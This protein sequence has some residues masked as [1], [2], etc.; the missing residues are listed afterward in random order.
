MWSTACSRTP[1][2][3]VS[4]S[5]PSRRASGE[6]SALNANGLFVCWSV[7]VLASSGID[8]DIKIWS[9]L[10]ETPS[11]NRVLANEVWLPAISVD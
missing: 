1:M 6:A 8:Y 10:E 11:F 5:P 7:S 3:R 9:P 4:P 2:T